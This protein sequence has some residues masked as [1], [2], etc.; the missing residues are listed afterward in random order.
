VEWRARSAGTGLDMTLL[1]DATGTGLTDLLSHPFIQHAFLGGT[2]IAIACGLVGYFLVLRAQVFSAD[3]L[4]HVAFTGALAA[5]AFGFDARLGLFVAT[6][7]IGLALGLLGHLGRPD[8]V[9]IGSVFTWILGIG[10]LFLSIFTTENSSGNSTGGTSVLFG[11]I[12][13]LSSG[14]ASLAA[15]VGAAVALAIVVIARP[16]LFA[17]L[18]QDVAAARG[19]PVRAFGV[20]FLGI[21]GVCA[22][23]ATQAVGALLLLALL[24]APA[25]TAQRLTNRPYLAFLL[26]PAIAVACVWGGIVISYLVAN[27]PPS[28]AI[29][30]LA[31]GF[32]FVTLVLTTLRHR[33]PR[34]FAR[35]GNG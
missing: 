32:Y 33:P 9:V 14:Q 16:L 27:V 15:W 8:D 13:G 26:S 1:A 11:S 22:G 18:D 21:V 34:A 10:V 29:V 35:Y 25:G 19:I 20:V 4:S 28:F 12:F 3:A 2:A 31:A 17:T 30:A 5:L 24:A 7:G 23:E 6:I